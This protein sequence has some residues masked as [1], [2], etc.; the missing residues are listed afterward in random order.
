MEAPFIGD[1]GISVLTKSGPVNTPTDVPAG[2]VR[3]ETEGLIIA[4][5]FPTFDNR[6]QCVYSIGLSLSR[7]ESRDSRGC[8]V[9][10]AD[11]R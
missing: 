4:G 5:I 3:L 9:G 11:N 7:L 6:I 8:E 1:D 10:F 2:A